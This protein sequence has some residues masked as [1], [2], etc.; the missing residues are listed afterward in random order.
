MNMSAPHTPGDIL[1]VD[2][3]PAN[4]RLLSQMLAERGH[5]VRP[6]LSGPQAL[7]AAQAAPPDLILLD[8]RMP[9]MDGYE[10][11]QRLKAD[12]CTRD[13]P[14]L[15][16]SALSETEDKVKAFTAGG[17]DYVTK[18]FQAAE[19]LARVQTHLALRTLYRQLQTANRTLEERNLELEVRY[20]EL[21]QAL[22]TIKT[23]SG[24]VPIC[25]WC[26]RKIKDD[27]GNWVEVEKYIMEHS[28]AQFTHSIC[29]ECAEKL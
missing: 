29:P 17:V 25:A 23:L 16:I 26:R 24:I 21:A 13:I 14:V 9:D 18:P 7:M 28:Q 22:S 19:V 15:F 27:D 2:D 20:A 10:V 1:I 4:L 3:T 5:R 11:C 8:I 12:E 6:V